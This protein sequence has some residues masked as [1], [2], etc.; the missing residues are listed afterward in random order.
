MVG[1]VVDGDTIEGPEVRQ[2]FLDS[3]KP[4]LVP[5]FAAPGA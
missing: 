2:F 4:S 5:V 1:E 3:H